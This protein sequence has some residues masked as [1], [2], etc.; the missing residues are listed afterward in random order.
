MI[1]YQDLFFKA[2]NSIIDNFNFLKRFGKL[3]D[4]LIGLLNEKKSALKAG[5]EQS[6]MKKK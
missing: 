5:K 1:N 4:L 6:E 3:Y 2:G